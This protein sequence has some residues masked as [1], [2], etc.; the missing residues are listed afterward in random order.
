MRQIHNRTHAEYKKSSAQ[1]SL[2]YILGI[3][4]IERIDTH[5][6]H[7]LENASWEFG[8]IEWDNNAAKLITSTIYYVQLHYLFDG[9]GAETTTI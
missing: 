7:N 4:I 6:H 2:G 1:F 9:Q 8:M 5:I 3:L